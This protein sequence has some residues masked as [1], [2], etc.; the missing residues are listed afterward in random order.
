M[1]A[2]LEDVCAVMAA[3]AAE[4]TGLTVLAED[5]MAIAVAGPV[6]IVHATSG[7]ITL[8]VNDQEWLDS[9]RLDFYCSLAKLTPLTIKA[10]RA[11]PEV[12]GDAFTPSAGSSS[13]FTLGGIVDQCAIVGYEFGVVER[14]GTE[15][16]VVRFTF[17]VKRHRY[18]GDE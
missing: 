3:R 7:T 11:L 5:P 16:S 8:R 6:G 14:T 9:V 13:K 4:A 10:L 15:Y 18:A 12:V 2:R 1:G 17:T